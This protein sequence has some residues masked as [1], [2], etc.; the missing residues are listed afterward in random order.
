MGQTSD[1]ETLVM[2]QKTTPGSNPEDLSNLND[3]WKVTRNFTN[4]TP[5]IPP[6]KHKGK[7]G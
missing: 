5:K 7:T 4:I 3:T 2:H 6:S 1:P